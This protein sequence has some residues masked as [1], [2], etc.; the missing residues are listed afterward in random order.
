M[1]QDRRSPPRWRIVT[2][3]AA[4][5]RRPGTAF[6]PPS[7]APTARPPR[8]RARYLGHLDQEKALPQ[9]LP[10]QLGE[11]KGA[12]LHA[13]RTY[14]PLGAEGRRAFDVAAN[15]LPRL[16]TAYLRAQDRPRAGRRSP[17][18]RTPEGGAAH[19]TSSTPP[20]G[21]G[22]HRQES[23]ES[24]RADCWP[25][26]LGI[27]SPWRECMAQTCWNG[28]PSAAPSPRLAPLLPGRR[29]YKIPP[30]TSIAPSIVD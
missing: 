1:L 22:S 4:V 24:L 6:A 30:G 15:Q 17:R 16:G 5:W 20:R 27:R 28:P 14:I 3:L 19:A 12:V 8:S 23:R 2:M 29:G 26:V 9:V 13:G 7:P 10:A 18:R 21:T 11:L 25:C